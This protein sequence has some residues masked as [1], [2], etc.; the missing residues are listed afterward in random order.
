[1]ATPLICGLVAL[2][3]L[4]DEHFQDH[5]VVADVLAVAAIVTVF[6]RTGHQPRRQRPPARER[7]RAVADRRPDR[8]RQPARAAARARAPV[9]AQTAT[10]RCSRSTT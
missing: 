3:V 10:R 6:I 5:N 7:A 1:M 2:A 9:L 4:V 8:A